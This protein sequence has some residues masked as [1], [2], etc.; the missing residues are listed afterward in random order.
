MPTRKVGFGAAAG[1]LAVLV[2]WLLKA[3]KTVDDVPAEIGVA[4][5]SVFT[6]AVQ[7]MVPDAEA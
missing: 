6:F 4:L 2:V 3:T 1:A 7:Y 5:T